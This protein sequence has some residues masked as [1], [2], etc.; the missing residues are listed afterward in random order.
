MAVAHQI[1]D[2]MTKHVHTV[3]TDT[4]LLVVARVM[5]DQ[6]IGDV[7]VT[8]EDGALC[9]IVTDRD[10]VVRAVA[11][12]K[13]LDR[14]KVS[15]VCSPDLV[16]VDVNASIEEVVRIMREHAIRRVPV[17]HGDKPIGIVSIGDLARL[18]DPGSALADIS[19]A[20]PNN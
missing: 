20:A 19:S 18:K 3:R 17:V 11:S 8:D 14:T 9:G 10:I 16:R 6:Q 15:E 1:Q 12:G 7:L 5:R 13:P 2:I 4:P